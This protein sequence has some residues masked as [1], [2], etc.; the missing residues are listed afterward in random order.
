MHNVVALQQTVHSAIKLLDCSFIETDAIQLAWLASMA[1]STRQP[2]S[3]IVVNP[4]P[5]GVQ[6]VRIQGLTIVNLVE[7]MALLISICS[8]QLVAS[9]APMNHIR[10]QYLLTPV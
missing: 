4:V 5:E 7:T 2:T 8:E 10:G 6:P 3:L 9:L 1:P